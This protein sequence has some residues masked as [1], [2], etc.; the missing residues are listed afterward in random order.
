MF[1]GHLILEWVRVVQ[2]RY[3]GEESSKVK[4]HNCGMNLGFELCSRQLLRWLSVFT[5]LC[6]L[7]ALS[8][9]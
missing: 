1:E 5:P 9:G 6:N 4:E 8:V 2:F 3:R 7:L